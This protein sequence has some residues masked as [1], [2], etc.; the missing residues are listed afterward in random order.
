MASANIEVV[1]VVPK[2]IRAVLR[3]AVL[4]EEI[5]GDQPWNDAAQEL[6][7]A[8]KYA[9]KRIAVRTIKSGPPETGG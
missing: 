3:A 6:A 8:L 4:A 2:A 7:K 1:I 9:A 5:A